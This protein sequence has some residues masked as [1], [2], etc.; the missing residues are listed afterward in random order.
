MPDYVLDATVVA[1][2]NRDI[3]ARRLGN[4]VDRR[5][6]VIQQVV[7]GAR[8]LRYN[9]KLLGEYQRLTQNSRDDVIVLFFIILDS[10]RSVFVGRNTLSR[11][12]YS[13]AVDRCRWPGHD[14]HLLAAALDGDDSTIVVT[15]SRLAQCATRI[16]RYFHVHVEYLA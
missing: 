15:E 3:V 12:N 11:Q 1:P 7:A 8:R 4:A 5:L 6:A 10:A 14:Q 13:T 2:P 9:T 16:L